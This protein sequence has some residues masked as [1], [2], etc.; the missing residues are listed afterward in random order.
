VQTIAS[1]NL[2]AGNNSVN[3]NFGIIGMDL[4]V[5]INCTPETM[6]PGSGATCTVIYTN[7]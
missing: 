1:V 6:I 5:E 2:I 3:N 4:T 7:I